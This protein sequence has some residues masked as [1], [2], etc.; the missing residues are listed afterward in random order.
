MDAP[1]RTTRYE[2]RET[3][4]GLRELMDNGEWTLER[5]RMAAGWLLTSDF[6][7]GDPGGVEI[8]AGL[9]Q[10]FD[11]ITNLERGR[12]RNSAGPASATEHGPDVFYIGIEPAPLE[13]ERGAAPPHGCSAFGTGLQRDRF[14]FLRTCPFIHCY[15]WG[16]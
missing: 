12:P 8:P 1:T 3:R 7:E 10:P 5:K 16:T 4:N 9:E 13:V 6:V 11:G 15:L 2:R 14:L